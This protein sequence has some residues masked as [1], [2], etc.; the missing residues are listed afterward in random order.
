LAEYVI[1]MFTVVAVM[2]RVRVVYTFL[3]LMACALAPVS[4]L[5]TTPDGDINTDGDVDVVDHWVMD[6]E[7]WKTSSHPMR[8]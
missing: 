5:A 2:R 1:E 6:P 7:G 8:A 4:V 3:M